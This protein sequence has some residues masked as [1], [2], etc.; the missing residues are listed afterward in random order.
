LS[1]KN[2][3][4]AHLV[5]PERRKTLDIRRQTYSTIGEV[6]S[7]ERIGGRLGANLIADYAGFMD[8]FDYAQYRFN[9]GEK[10]WVGDRRVGVRKQ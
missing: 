7:G 10:A 9:G 1:I 8:S 6:I 4:P 3:I 2:G 5:A